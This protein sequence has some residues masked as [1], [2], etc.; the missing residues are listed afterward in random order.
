[1]TEQLLE[2]TNEKECS[3]MTTI[4]SFL[5]AAAA[6]AALT[7]PLAIPAQ[8]VAFNSDAAP[9]PDSSS[10]TPAVTPAASPA[11]AIPSWETTF[12]RWFDLNA[13][14]Y[15]ARYR[16]VLDVDGARSFDQG[17]ERFIADGKF[18]FDPDG[19]YGIGW[20]LSSG[21]YFN[22]AYAG[23]IGGGQV[24]F[25]NA[26]EQNMSPEQLYIMNVAPFQ[27]GFFN[28]DGAAVYFRQA[29]LTAQPIKG[30]EVQFGGLGIDRGVNTEAT[31]Y[32]D[33]G[34]IDGERISIRRPKQLFFS[35]LSFTRAY[36]GDSY[37][38]NFFARGDELAISNYRQY[39]A[40]K[41]FGKRVSASADYTYSEPQFGAFYLKTVREAV[42]ANIHESKAFDTVRYEAYQRLNS[43][44]YATGYP[45]PSGHGSAL[46]VSKNFF[47]HASVEAGYADI[48]LNYI[49]N[50]GLDVQALILG[51]TVNG[52]QYG[53]GNRWFVR[54][55]IPLT[56]A[57]SLE[58]N[59]NHLYGHGVEPPVPTA[60]WNAQ[61]ISAGFVIDGKK[62]FFHQPAVH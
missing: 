43:G 24:G 8:Q 46:T 44:N 7:L 62:L 45:F 16:S 33:D 9:T 38:P 21:R 27:P 14:S 18:K 17:Q 19:R 23:F 39:L 25:I 42:L 3:V 6:C 54:P 49:T 59:F 40:R 48:D 29:F 36:I 31:S 56:K 26:T 11:P 1:M 22:W 58:G 28:S 50:M 57:V 30:I 47:N 5:R 60:I 37:T 41:D 51:L 52:D 53:V 15:G 55:T 13:L 10:S 12:D 32:D 34:Y 4:Q 61:V 35:E 2:F 20:H